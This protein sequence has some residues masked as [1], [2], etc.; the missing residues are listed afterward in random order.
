MP[1]HQMTE[2]LLPLDDTGIATHLLCM[3]LANWQ[4]QYELMENTTP[5]STRASLLVLENIA[6][7]TEVDYYAQNPTNTLGAEGKHKMK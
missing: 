2:K 4:T 1:L 7:N 3:S 6:N 5:I